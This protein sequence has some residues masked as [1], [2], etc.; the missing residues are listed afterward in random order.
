M[1]SGVPVRGWHQ[2]FGRYILCLLLI[3]Q[4]SVMV[5]LCAMGRSVKAHLMLLLAGGQHI[6]VQLAASLMMQ[7][8]CC[9]ARYLVSTLADIR[10]MLIFGNAASLNLQMP[11]MMNVWVTPHQTHHGASR[12]QHT[13]TC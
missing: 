10:R 5:A 3:K 2:R 4:A 8:F 9:V 6:R 7:I 12:G 13:L 11:I 1:A